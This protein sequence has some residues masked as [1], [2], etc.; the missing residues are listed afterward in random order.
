MLIFG[1]IYF[2]MN[3]TNRNKK[4]VRFVYGVSTILGVMSIIM[5]TILVVD[6]ARGLGRSDSYLIGNQSDTFVKDI[7]GGQTTVDIIRYVVLGIMGLYAVPLLLY[8]ICFR[9]LR[10][11]T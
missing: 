8:S 5:L 4:F 9:T 2:S 3:L 6:L 11:I 1:L 10:V 7:P